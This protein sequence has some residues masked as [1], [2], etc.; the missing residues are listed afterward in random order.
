MK[1]LSEYHSL[2]SADLHAWK[3][4]DSSRLPKSTCCESGALKL[5]TNTEKKKQEL[6]GEKQSKSNLLSSAATGVLS[7]LFVTSKLSGPS[8]ISVKQNVTMSF[9]CLSAIFFVAQRA[10]SLAS[11]WV[12]SYWHPGKPAWMICQATL[13]A[14]FSA[15]TRGSRRVSVT[16][17]RISEN[18][19]S[20]RLTRMVQ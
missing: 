17:P 2:G 1:C 3:A 12:S 19:C 11:R 4:W 6:R 14:G 10:I 9:V 8:M 20:S 16:W 15:M 18:S 7:P 5:R 13:P